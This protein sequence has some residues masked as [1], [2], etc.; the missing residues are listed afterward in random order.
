M[1]DMS[2]EERLIEAAKKG[3]VDALA[4]A[5][6]DGA[7]AGAALLGAAKNGHAECVKLLLPLSDPREFDSL[8]L[9]RA[10]SRGHVE[11]VKILIPVSDPKAKG[12]WALLE[13]AQNGH[14]Q[15]V[16]LLLPVSDPQGLGPCAGLGAAGEARAEGHVEVAGMIEAFIEGKAL[17]DCAQ[18]AKK[19]P[20]AKS[21]L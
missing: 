20:R 4:R 19:N 14:A 15:C 8:A 12:S 11:C 1:P 17:S 2:S 10:A 16:A 5:L 18:K 6:N 21:A 7:N 3:D 9:V 13:A